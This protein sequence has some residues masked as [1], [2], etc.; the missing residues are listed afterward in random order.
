MDPLKVGVATVVVAVGA[1]G[2]GIGVSKYLNT[3]YSLKSFLDSDDGKSKRNEYSSKLGG[4][5]K[6]QKLFVANT[7]SNDW[8]W[9]KKY[10]EL[11]Q[12]ESKSTEFNAATDYSEDATDTNSKAINKL[13]DDAYKKD[14]STISTTATDT[15]PTYKQDIAKYCTVSSQVDD[16][17]WTTT[18]GAAG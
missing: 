1:T 15:N 12:A 14:P 11:Q 8:W 3:P 16:I 9:R 4:I 7:K 2:T 10:K 18:T 6:N 17:T 13:C 5:D